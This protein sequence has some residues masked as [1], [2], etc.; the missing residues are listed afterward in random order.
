MGNQ[1]WIIK[2]NASGALRQVLVTTGGD[3]STVGED[4]TGKT[5]YQMVRRGDMDN[6]IP[7]LTAG[8]WSDNLAFVKA[9]LLSTIDTQRE[10]NQ[11]M[12]LTTGGAKKMIYNQKAYEIINY[13]SLG[14]A[15]VALLNL[16]DQRARFPAA[17]AEMDLTGDNLATVIARFSAGAD[18]A[19]T[20][21]YKI[22]ALAQRAKRGVNA[23]T[24]TAAAI[25]AANVNWT[26]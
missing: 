14:S 22:E 21:A 19:N 5:G 7:N 25:A 24:T 6:E 16:Q 10:T 9:N 15:A 26:V 17:F 20:K 18:S 13:R 8:T 23:A 2:D 3:P 4:M 12:W 11:M 1:W